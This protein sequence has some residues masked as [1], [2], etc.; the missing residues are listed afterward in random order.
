VVQ[1]VKNKLS[2]SFL[3]F[4]VCSLGKAEGLVWSPVITKQGDYNSVGCLLVGIVSE[5]AS[6][7]LGLEEQE[8]CPWVLTGLA[9]AG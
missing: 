5:M 6:S 1:S 7:G 9:L 8:I 2:L 4:F 3:I